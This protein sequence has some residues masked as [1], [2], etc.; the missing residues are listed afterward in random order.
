MGFIYLLE[1]VTIWVYI[2]ILGRVKGNF[3]K[4]YCWVWRPK[5][6]EWASHPPWRAISF[7]HS[8]E[9]EA[10]ILK[11]SYQVWKICHRTDEQV[12]LKIVPFPQ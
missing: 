2:P 5:T 3:H 4:K 9:L 12:A 11:E 6:D 10:C 8:E 7:L 1:V